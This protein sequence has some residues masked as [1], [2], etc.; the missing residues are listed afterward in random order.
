MWL[1]P[2]VR[3]TYFLQA[4]TSPLIRTIAVPT[5]QEEAFRDFMIV[6]RPQASIEEINTILYEALQD[7]VELQRKAMAAIAY[8]REWLTNT[9]K[10][11]RML[12]DVQAYRRVGRLYHFFTLTQS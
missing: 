6:L 1:R 3:L 2:I 5:E 7:P 12:S 11:D 4:G 9:R 8:A 10:V